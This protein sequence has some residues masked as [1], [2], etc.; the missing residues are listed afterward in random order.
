MG[1]RRYLLDGEGKLLGTA[2]LGQ[3]E[4]VSLMDGNS[5]LKIRQGKR[6]L[7]IAAVGGADQIEQ[8]LVLRDRQE[9]AFAEHPS[10]RSEV[11]REHPDFA[12][13]RWRHNDRS[14]G[15]GED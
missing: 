10:G 11:A 1:V 3:N 7:S 6:G 2:R 5:S 4:T 8:R 15:L 12:Y 9:L 14:V 13:I